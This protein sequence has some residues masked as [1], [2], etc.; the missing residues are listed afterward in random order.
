MFVFAIS[1][2]CIS[3]RYA[4]NEDTD[5]AVDVTAVPD[6]PSPHHDT[7]LPDTITLEPLN[8]AHL[9]T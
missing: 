2:C 3:D 5:G 9:G 4:V 8:P 1:R 6:V 7:A